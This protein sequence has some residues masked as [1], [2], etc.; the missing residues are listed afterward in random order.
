MT[1][2]DTGNGMDGTTLARV[3]GPLF[4]ST[5]AGDA[6]D[7]CLEMVCEFLKQCRGRAFV[8]SEPGKGTTV[9]LYFPRAEGAVEADEAGEAKIDFPHAAATILLVED[10]EA[11]RQAVARTLREFG[12]TVVK[13]A[14]RGRRFRLPNIMK[15]RSIC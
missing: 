1:I 15:A 9:K 2:T 14:G 5:P 4:T 3:F 10:D 12:Y 6:S 8:Q 7:S 13:L 11:C